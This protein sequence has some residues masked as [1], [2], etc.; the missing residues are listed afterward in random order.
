MYSLQSDTRIIVNSK[1]SMRFPNSHFLDHPSTTTMHIAQSV[2]S[3]AD[4][5]CFISASIALCRSFNSASKKE[6]NTEGIYIHTFYIHFLT[7][8]FLKTTPSPLTYIILTNRTRLIQA[9]ISYYCCR[10]SA[11]LGPLRYEVFQFHLYGNMKYYLCSCQAYL[12]LCHLR[13]SLFSQSVNYFCKKSSNIYVGKGSK[14]ISAAVSISCI[15]IKKKKNVK[16]SDTNTNLFKDFSA[17]TLCVKHIPGFPQ[18]SQKQTNLKIHA[19]TKNFFRLNIFAIYF[20]LKLIFFTV[21]M[22]LFE[23]KFLSLC[24]ED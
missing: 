23:S 13:W 16:I 4:I 11:L 18:L 8:R 7:K 9:T 24:K 1:Q 5:S 17:N 2:L 10:F 3:C 19:L 20:S 12:E 6:N 22:Y 21:Q 14:Y 15:L